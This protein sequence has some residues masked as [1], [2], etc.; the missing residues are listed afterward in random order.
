MTFSVA[1]L[2]AASGCQSRAHNDLYRQRMASEI[3]VLEDQLYDADYQN[4]VL[5]EKLE[6]AK[7]QTVEPAGPLDPQSDGPK[8]NAV[9]PSASTPPS[10]SFDLEGEFDETMIDPGIADPDALVPSDRFESPFEDEPSWETDRSQLPL[11]PPI[12]GPEPPG[13]SDTEFSPIEPG[14]LLPPPNPG[15]EELPA[16]PGQIRLPDAV[17][18][19]EPK[20]ST[21][22]RLE[23]HLGLSGAKLPDTATNSD[24]P[25]GLYLVVRAVDRLGAAVN[26]QDFEIDAEL[27]VVVLDPQRE[28]SEAKI[29]RWEF[30]PEEVKGLTKSRPVSGL[31]IPIEWQQEEPLGEEVIVHIRLRSEADEMRCEGHVKVTESAMIAKWLPRADSKE[32]DVDVI[33]R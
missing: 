10:D 11:P 12:G 7:R 29:G 13:K 9:P 18:A 5:R 26:L 1:W 30:S 33:A 6:R 21:P 8:L 2:L 27:T 25:D 17:K 19:T 20:R 23:L 14:E 16:P 3:R 22:E 32:E 28:A 31:H 24:T 15:G 4:R